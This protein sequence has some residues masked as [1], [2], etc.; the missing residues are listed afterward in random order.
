ML[1]VVALLFPF[2]MGISRMY[3]GVHS[4][5]DVLGGVA[6]SVAGI[7]FVQRTKYFVL[8]YLLFH[9]LSPYIH[10]ILLLLFLVLF[11]PKPPESSWRASFGSAAQFFGTFIGCSSST[12]FIMTQHPRIWQ[13]LLDTSSS[14]LTIKSY[15]QL[16]VLGII[17]S[18]SLS[19]FVKE[20]CRYFFISLLSKG[21][22]SDDY[23]YDVFQRPVPSKYRYC[24]D[25]ASR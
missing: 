10:V 2:L 9:H 21:Y 22:V 7:L 8:N 20:G 1:W 16:S 11:M 5:S 3:L 18:A 17:V 12:W 4:F 15:M 19:H 24:V 14:T 23:P 25:I 13:T 6:I